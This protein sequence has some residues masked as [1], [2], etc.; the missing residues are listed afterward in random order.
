MNFRSPSLPRRGIKPGTCHRISRN[1][2][3]IW[4]SRR[5]ANIKN[6]LEEWFTRNYTLFTSHTQSEW[7]DGLWPI[8]EALLSNDLLAKY[9]VYIHTPSLNE[10][11]LGKE[12]RFIS[13]EK[14]CNK[15][16]I[17]DIFWS[18]RMNPRYS[19]TRNNVSYD[20]NI[21]LDFLRHLCVRTRLARS[22]VNQK[23][24]KG[25]TLNYKKAQN[26]CYGWLQTM[27]SSRRPW[28]VF[29]ALWGL[30]LA[31]HEQVT[32]LSFRSSLG[33]QSI[34]RLWS[35]NSMIKTLKKKIK[36]FQWFWRWQ[37]MGW[38]CLQSWTNRSGMPRDNYKKRRRKKWIMTL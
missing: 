10:K 1:C 36:R 25:E 6:T 8:R 5:L 28:K 11:N 22:S 31:R 26:G 30:S 37:N 21:S 32:W 35:S 27:L 19:V 4:V 23:P 13:L 14:N 2:V 12:K 15:T 16:T 24:L 20:R 9:S 7:E 18:L 29:A 3:I 34:S 33:P 17:R 38:K